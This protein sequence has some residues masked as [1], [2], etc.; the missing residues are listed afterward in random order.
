MVNTFIVHKEYL[1]SARELDTKRLQKQ[2]LEAYQILHI[3]Y[4]FQLI[5]YHLGRLDDLSKIMPAKYGELRSEMDKS[6]ER[7]DLIKRIRSDYLAE[8]KIL[9]KFEDDY[10]YCVMHKED[11][12]YKVKENDIIECTECSNEK[13][14]QTFQ[15]YEDICDIEKCGHDSPLIFFLL[16]DPKNS[17]SRFFKFTGEKCLRYAKRV[18][19]SIPRDKV[20]SKNTEMILTGFGQHA[21]VKMWVGYE[22]SLY[23]YITLHLIALEERGIKMRLKHNEVIQKMFI[24]VDHVIKPWWITSHRSVI[25]SHRASLLR[26]ELKNMPKSGIFPPQRIAKPHLS[27]LSKRYIDNPSFV[28]AKVL[29][30]I[31]FG[32]VWTNSLKLSSLQFLNATF[33]SWDVCA[34]PQHYEVRYKDSI[35]QLLK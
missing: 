15:S 2:C 8:K 21:I 7:S 31:P 18:G 35:E 19:Y 1:K 34:K 10:D 23:E 28:N 4:Q 32:Y 14:K 3:L 33:P 27:S 6:R 11:L 12:P 30:W 24:K 9:V 13:A 29:E 26:K 17:G 5:L 20:C 22:Q 25:L 16:A